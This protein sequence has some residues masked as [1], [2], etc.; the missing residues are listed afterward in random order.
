MKHLP[1]RFIACLHAFHA[2]TGD[3]FDGLDGADLMLIKLASPAPPQWVPQRMAFGL[4]ETIT[5]LM[6]SG[7][8]SGEGANDAAAMGL[9]ELIGNPSL[10]VYGFGDRCQP[11]HPP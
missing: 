6:K 11:T 5:G 4:E 2:H 10:Q 8:K 3:G 7:S 1:V 9:T